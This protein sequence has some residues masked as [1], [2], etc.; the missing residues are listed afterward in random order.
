MAPLM[1]A[2]VAPAALMAAVEKNMSSRV[3]IIGCEGVL[4]SDCISSGVFGCDRRSSSGL[5]LA[6]AVKATAKK[7]RRPQI[8]DFD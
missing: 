3:I 2:A 6:V 4:E 1:I 7:A 8:L 5:K